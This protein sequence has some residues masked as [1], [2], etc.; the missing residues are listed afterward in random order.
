V[1]DHPSGAISFHQPLISPLRVAQH[2][3]TPGGTLVA[4]QEVLMKTN[5]TQNG[6]QTYFLLRL[7]V[8]PS[9]CPSCFVPFPFPS[10]ANQFGRAV[11]TFL[12]YPRARIREREREREREGGGGAA[13]EA[14]LIRLSAGRLSRGRIAFSSERNSRE[15]T[16]LGIDTPIL[17][18]PRQS[19]LSR[20]RRPAGHWSMSAGSY[21]ARSVSRATH[22]S[23]LAT[24]GD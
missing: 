11:F 20:F 2:L 4:P 23:P 22:R 1:G 15:R 8:S 5:L 17:V 12:F 10:L 3:V 18:E 6:G 13:G 14:I 7:L 19:A 9:V 21:V 16:E 24:P